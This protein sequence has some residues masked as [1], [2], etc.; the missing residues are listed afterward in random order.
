MVHSNLGPYFLAALY[1]PPVQGEQESIH[2]LR[3]ECSNLARDAI[4]IIIVGDLNIHHAK[5]LG[6]SNRNSAEGEELFKF[7]CDHGMQQHM[8]E[9][10]RDKYLL[11]L[12]LSDVDHIK[13]KALPKIAHH[14][15]V[16]ICLDIPVPEI[17]NNERMVWC[18]NKAD[19]SGLQSV[20]D[21]IDWNIWMC[22]QSTRQHVSSEIKCLMQLGAI[23]QNA[24]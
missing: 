5:W 15:I 23:F 4:G 19:W 17:H 8:K 14:E 10:T 6:K 12:V 9:A 21:K 20:L 11:D 24:S 16:K 3:K 1:R 22:S 18:Y 13:C 2:S 7:C